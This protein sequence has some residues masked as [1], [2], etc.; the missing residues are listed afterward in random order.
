[1]K[2]SE[3]HHLHRECQPEPCNWNA[4]TP[5]LSAAHNGVG[6][7]GSITGSR[8]LLLTLTPEH[9]T[10]AEGKGVSDVSRHRHLRRSRWVKMKGGE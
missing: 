9:R 3:I 7:V 6:F 4:L 10:R 1:M 2:S 8:G 5:F